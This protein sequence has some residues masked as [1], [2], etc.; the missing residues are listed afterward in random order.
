MAEQTN[1]DHKQIKRVADNLADCK[2]QLIAIEEK[3]KPHKAKEKEFKKDLLTIMK[4]CGL[5]RLLKVGREK[6]M[7][8]QFFSRDVAPTLN[9]EAL[10]HLMS[11]Y[12]DS[13]GGAVRAEPATFATF[14]VAWKLRNGK[15]SEGIRVARSSAK[16]KEDDEEEGE[17]EAPPL[18]LSA[19][20]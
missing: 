3:A 15:K 8:I 9:Q 1:E 16:K 14:F 7:E 4:R 20:E 5:K 19:L 18:D 17:R 12:L 6:D 11:E 10:N 13:V 2:A